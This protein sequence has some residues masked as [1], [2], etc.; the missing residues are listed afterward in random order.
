MTTKIMER[1]IDIYNHRSVGDMTFD[2]L[3]KKHGISRER[4][5]QI[6]YKMCTEVF[7]V[8]PTKT[9]RG[10]EC[11]YCKRLIYDRNGRVFCS[12]VCRD[13]GQVKRAQDYRKTE[14]YQEYR[15]KKRLEYKLTF[16]PKQY[17]MVC[18]QKGCGVKFISNSKKKIYCG[19]NK[20]KTGCSYKR[21][22]S[23]S[24]SEYGGWFCKDCQEPIQPRTRGSRGQNKMGGYRCAE[25]EHRWW[26]WKRQQTVAPYIKE[27]KAI[28]EA[29]AK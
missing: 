3:S 1:A 8:D 29:R 23:F 21:Q 28:V 16:K 13:L 7:F 22:A 11:G 5:R 20:G 6:D 19:S 10:R 25:C 24:Y 2:E 18:A 15:A 14:K 26:R 27:I 12:N 4:V 9:I 17:E